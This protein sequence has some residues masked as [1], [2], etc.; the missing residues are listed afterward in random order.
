MAMCHGASTS[1]LKCNTITSANRKGIMNS[2]N[3]AFFEFRI[4]NL[5]GLKVILVG[6]LKP[7]W[8]LMLKWQTWSICT[9]T[10]RF[11]VTHH[12]YVLDDTIAILQDAL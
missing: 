8:N 9:H 4:Q 2:P 11:Q 10:T 3:Y 7:T 6:Y 1:R 5:L 12:A